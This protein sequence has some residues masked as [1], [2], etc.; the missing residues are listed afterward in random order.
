[1]PPIAASVRLVIAAIFASLATVVFALDQRL[2]GAVCALPA[3]LMVAAWF[4]YHDVPRAER[5]FN[6]RQRDA[7]WE[8]LAG[9][10]FGGRW[11]RREARVYRHHVRSLCLIHDEKWAEAAAEAEAA[12]AVPGIAEE[13]P[14]CH[15][16]AAKAYA[17]LGDSAKARAH[18]DAAR[19]LPHGDAVDKGLARLDRML[20]SA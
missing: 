2:W 13:A 6:A 10:P 5:A 4:R 9:V 11:L 14:G 12:L 17:F 1:M 16:A 18:A 3:V 20:G 8:L 15:V 7:A 19:K